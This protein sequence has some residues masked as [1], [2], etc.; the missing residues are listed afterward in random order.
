MAIHIKKYFLAL[1]IYGV[2]IPIYFKKDSKYKNAF[3]SIVSLIS[4]IIILILIIIFINEL[5]SKK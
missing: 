3:G 5:V 4:F 1:D 2:D